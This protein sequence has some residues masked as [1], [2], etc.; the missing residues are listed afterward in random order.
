MKMTSAGLALILAAAVARA[1]DVPPTWQRLDGQ[2]SGITGPLAVA[3]QDAQ[4]WSKIWREHDA[5][6]PVP[7]VDFSCED[8]VAVFLGDKRTAGVK[9]GIVVQ[10][11]PR[12][13]S[14]LNVFY[15]EIDGAKGFA[16]D[17]ISQPYAIVKVPRAAVIDVEPD[18]LVTAPERRGGPARSVEPGKIRAL[19]VLSSPS[20]DGR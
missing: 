10:K 8:V 2:H 3:V 9:V 5:A 7:P 19:V 14:R 6:A 20:F 16:A 17:V 13:A 1:Q 15:R 18:A 12:D 4:E 11:D